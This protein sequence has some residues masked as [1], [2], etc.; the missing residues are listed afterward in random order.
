M[1]GM[2]R[3]AP[4]ML[5]TLMACGSGPSTGGGAPEPAAAT[6]RPAAETVEMAE[7]LLGEWRVVL[8][9]AEERE[10]TEALSELQKLGDNADVRAVQDHVRR[11]VEIGMTVTEE[12]MVLHLVDKEVPLAWTLVHDQ[13]GGFAVQTTDAMGL[14]QTWDVKFDDDLLTMSARSGTTVSR[15]RRFP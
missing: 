7:K 3:L 2:R 11:A 14:S 6:P 8:T 15:F 1:A 12:Q 4:I 13:P 5:V 10:R 9:A